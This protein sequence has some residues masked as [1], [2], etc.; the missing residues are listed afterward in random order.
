MDTQIAVANGA[1]RQSEDLEHARWSTEGNA[2]SQL[3]NDVYRAE[4]EELFR[5]GLKIKD[6]RQSMID[7]HNLRA[8]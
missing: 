8:S 3:L 5:Q 2:V 6:I 1:N 7:V 4:I